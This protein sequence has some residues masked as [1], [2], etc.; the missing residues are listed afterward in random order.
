AKK[1]DFSN[2]YFKDL[3]FIIIG[4]GGGSLEE[5]WAF[6]EEILARSIYNSKIPIVSAVGHET[7]FTISDFVADLR[8]PTPSAAAEMTI[9]DKN[10]LINNLSLLKSKMIR[11]VKRNL[12][13]KTENL[14]SASRS[15]KYQGPENRINQYYQY[16]DEFSARLNLR[17]KHRVELYGERIKKDSQRL[18]SLSPWAIIERGYSI[19]RKIPGKEIIKRLEQ[20][21][22]GAKIEVIISDGKILSKV[23]KK[24][25]VS[26]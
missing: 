11:A 8:S 1:I 19:C 12:E 14:N 21:E 7:D 20:I 16:I 26:N 2:K 25:A 9:P 22:V 17:I 18:D 3:D 5:L 24:E 15:L 23:E 6:N 13:L 10:N 4:R